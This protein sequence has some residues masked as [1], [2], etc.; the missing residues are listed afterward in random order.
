VLILPR[1]AANTAYSC[2]DLDPASWLRAGL[3][4]IEFAVLGYAIL[5]WRGSRPSKGTLEA[6]GRTPYD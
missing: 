2:G 1:G 5:R 6:V 4:I 3:I